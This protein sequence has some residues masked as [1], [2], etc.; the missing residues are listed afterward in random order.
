MAQNGKRFTDIPSGKSTWKML[1]ELFKSAD[2]LS[3]ETA[4]Q[5]A[6][7]GM[8]RGIKISLKHRK[9]GQLAGS[10]KTGKERLTLTSDLVM[11]VKS[12][13]ETSSY[14]SGRTIGRH[15]KDGYG[16]KNKIQLRK[17][18]VAQIRRTIKKRLKGDVDNNIRQHLRKYDRKLR[19]IQ[20]ARVV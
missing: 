8:R 14:L 17:K 13:L 6:H 3:E 10:W 12:T 19:I 5:A 7:A 9:T 20:R 1:D 11:V 2:K 15:G 16:V 18:V 4:Y